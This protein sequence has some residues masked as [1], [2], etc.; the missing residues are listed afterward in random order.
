MLY[1]EF[2]RAAY[3]WS[4]DRPSTT[5]WAGVRSR[6][7]NE[8]LAW[9]KHVKDHRQAA[10]DILITESYELFDVSSTI[11]AM[12][13]EIKEVRVLDDAL[14]E[15]VGHLYAGTKAAT[16]CMHRAGRLTSDADVA[17]VVDATL[18]MLFD[19]SPNG[20]DCCLKERLDEATAAAVLIQR[21]WR[22]VVA[23]PQRAAC[24][25]RLQRESEDLP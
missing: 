24:R 13:P 22:W 25:R 4:N 17:N 2:R 14:D 3:E 10:E 19:A 1:E 11:L 7:R 9:V 21:W 16:A 6:V 20:P 12:I 23:D 8:M 15:L 5:A 18:E